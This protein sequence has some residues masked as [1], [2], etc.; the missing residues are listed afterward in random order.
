MQR[1]R[2]LFVV[3]VLMQ[4]IVPSA[5]LLRRC[6]RGCRKPLLLGS[7]M[8]SKFEFVAAE[9]RELSRHESS[10]DLRPEYR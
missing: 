7:S 2:T 8:G 5:R 4:A 1:N 3:S 9:L 6:M 10:I